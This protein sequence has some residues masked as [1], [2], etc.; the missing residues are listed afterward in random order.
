MPKEI[1]HLLDEVDIGSGE[2]DAGQ[3]QTEQEIQS[4]NGR[5]QDGR[6]LQDVVEEQEYAEQRSA[7]D[8]RN[9]SEGENRVE[10]EGETGSRILRSGTHVARVT[11]APLPDGTYEAQVYVRLTREPKI[12]ETYIPAGSFITEAEA[13][14]AAEERARRALNEHE[15]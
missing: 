4:V 7:L 5:P 9:R 8:G 14:V 10:S 6:Q 13:W 3:R 1:G 2:K 15:F 11:I 12:A